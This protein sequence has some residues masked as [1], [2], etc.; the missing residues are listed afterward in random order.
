MG[1]SLPSCRRP[2][3]LWWDIQSAPRLTGGAALPRKPWCVLEG[4][5]SFQAARYGELTR[6]HLSNAGEFKRFNISFI[7]TVKYV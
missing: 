1:L 7:S 4:M 2:P 6:V 5:E 3:S